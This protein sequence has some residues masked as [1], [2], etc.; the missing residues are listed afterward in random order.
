[1][2]GRAAF[3]SAQRVRSTEE[4]FVG[5]VGR[6]G[7]GKGRRQYPAIESDGRL[8]RRLRAKRRADTPTA[9]FSVAPGDSGIRR[10]LQHQM[11]AA[12]QGRGP[13]LHDVQR[14]WAYFE[15]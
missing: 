5:G 9:R 3:A 15:G 13:L 11:A 14:L 4:R 8:H 7:R 6:L 2:D 1:M 12:D 10:D